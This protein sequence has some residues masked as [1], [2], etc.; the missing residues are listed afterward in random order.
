MSEHTSTAHTFWRIAE[1]IPSIK[2]E[3][4]ANFGP[5]TIA[6]TTTTVFLIAVFCMVV[7]F[8]L[9]KPKSK[10]GK[11]QNT[12]E[13]IYESILGLV[14]SIVGD[15]RRAKIV[16]PYIAAILCYIA[17]SNLL[18]MIPGLNAITTISASGEHTELFRGT[19]TD[20]NT[21]F[22]LAVAVVLILQFIGFKEQGIFG[23]LGHFLQFKQV[24]QGFRKSF[25]D[26]MVAIVGF[27][28]GLIEIIGELAKMVS[29]SLRLFGNM[30]AHEVLTVIL[31]GVFAFGLPAVWM[32][33]G[34]LVGMVQSIVFA[35]LVTVYYSLVLKKEGKD[36]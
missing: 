22:A 13:F 17:I 29:L 5:F 26:G 19:T 6:N 11:F 10:P 25:G 20:F 8:F 15:A 31:L 30:F 28:V 21:T 7:A 16:A 24:Y 1:G 14:T 23:Y 3:V 33:M 18:P 12:I 9:R 27:F 36:H 35:A 4:F 34:V 2:P 32:G